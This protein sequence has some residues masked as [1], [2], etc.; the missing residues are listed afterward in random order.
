MKLKYLI[1]ILAIIG[2]TA[3]QSDASKRAD[4]D[5]SKRAHLHYQ[6]GLDALHKGTVPKAFEELYIS[7]KI[8]PD[9]PE[10]LDAIAY[11]WRLRGNNKNAE[12]FYKKAIQEGAGAATYNNYGSL[13]IEFGKYDKAIE[14]FNAAL[15]D[16]TYRNQSLVFVNM[17][18][19]YV[20]LNNLEEAVKAYRKARLLSPNWTYP[21]LKEANAY[22]SFHRPNYAQALYETI[23]RREPAN[24]EALAELISLLKN[25]GQDSLLRSYIQTFIKTTLDKLQQAWAKDELALLSRG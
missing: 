8:K 7:D 17:G 3:C 5:T 16:P 11:A 15:E 18:D 24:Q 14:Q 10:T 4:E 25:K 9:Q 13:L 19:A 23:L 22:Q 2:L 21:Q 1:Y 6:L 20:G 12:K